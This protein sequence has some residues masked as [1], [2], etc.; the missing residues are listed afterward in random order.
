M[1]GLDEYS[2]PVKFSLGQRYASPKDATVCDRSTRDSPRSSMAGHRSVCLEKIAIAW[3]SPVPVTRDE[4]E[5]QRTEFWETAPA[6]GGQD[7]VWSAIREAIEVGSV[8]METARAILTSAGVTAPSGQLTEAYDDHGYRY[9]IPTYCLCDPANGLADDG[10]EERSAA[11][12]DVD[13]TD[14]SPFESSTDTATLKLK[15]SRGDDV[16]VALPRHPDLR[17]G[18]VKARV[19]QIWTERGR[20]ELFWAGHGPLA[21]SLRL[22]SIAGLEDSDRGRMQAWMFPP[23]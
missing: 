22:G 11:H 12:E 23:V 21:D 3:H 20:L 16:E 5:R 7:V 1:L 9:V 2:Y 10:R 17:V 18:H 19:R 15:L 6:Y 8:D 13:Y 4:L 14:L